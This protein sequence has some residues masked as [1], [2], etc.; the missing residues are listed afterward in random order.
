MAVNYQVC[1]PVP[2]CASHKR[3]MTGVMEREKLARAAPLSLEREASPLAGSSAPER[4]GL[5]GPNRTEGVN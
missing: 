1:S 2:G 5:R 4:F 3:L